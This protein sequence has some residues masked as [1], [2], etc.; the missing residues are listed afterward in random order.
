MKALK[1]PVKTKW[2]CFWQWGAVR[3]SRLVL[4]DWFNID[5]KPFLKRLRLSLPL[6]L[7]GVIISQLP[8]DVIWRYF[9]WANQT[10]AMIVLWAA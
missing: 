2:I 7:A 10:L 3:A 6:L 1:L 8:Y 5:Q 4:A 9:S